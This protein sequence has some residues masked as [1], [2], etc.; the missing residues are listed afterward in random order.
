MPAIR[1]ALLTHN[2]SWNATTNTLHRRDHLGRNRT[3]RLAWDGRNT[4][5][6]WQHDHWLTTM[7]KQEERLWKPRRRQDDSYAIGLRL[8]ALD[9]TH[10]PVMTAHRIGR[11]I[12]YTITSTP[13]RQI[14]VATGT[15]AWHQA[16]RHNTSMP[17]CLCGKPE[18]SMAH[19]LWVCPA[20]QRNQPAAPPAP[21]APR[22]TCEERLG[23]STAPKPITPLQPTELTPTP[24]A[25]L[26]QIIRTALTAAY[27]QHQ[28][29]TVATDGGSKTWMRHLGHRHS[30]R[31]HRRR[32]SG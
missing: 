19:L 16:A 28:T 22:N 27:A 18:P 26:L 10:L 17:P 15:S 7:Y 23:A 4:I 31:L 21:R 24:P 9:P 29:L 1:Q 3:I 5:R 12:P 8:P 2:I 6:D 14:Y 13:Q 11:N 25:R 20:I 32:N 30:L